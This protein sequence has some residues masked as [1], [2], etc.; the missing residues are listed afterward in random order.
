[1]ADVNQA[2]QQEA[3]K[4]PQYYGAQQAATESPP[5]RQSAAVLQALSERLQQLEALTKRLS[6]V[7]DRLTGPRPRD[8]SKDQILPNPSPNIVPFANS[9]QAIDGQLRRM[10]NECDATLA[11][12]ESFV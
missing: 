9:L 3:Q 5:K 8:V 6:M 10:L 12:I 1:M 11:S 7:C 2:Y 4:L